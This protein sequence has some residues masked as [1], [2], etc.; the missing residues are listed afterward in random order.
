MIRFPN[1]FL[2][3]F[4][5]VVEVSSF[6]GAN[7]HRKNRKLSENHHVCIGRSG[8]PPIDTGSSSENNV[9]P[10]KFPDPRGLPQVSW[11]DKSHTIPALIG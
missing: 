8:F 7:L 11:T 1:G 3:S 6:F 9:F 10:E 5:P 4:L 2:K